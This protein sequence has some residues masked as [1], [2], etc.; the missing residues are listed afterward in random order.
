MMKTRRK[1]KA[2]AETA[3]AVSNGGDAGPFTIDIPDDVDTDALAAVLPDAS[4]TTPSPDTVLA[5]YRLV[6][7]QGA[8]IDNANRELDAATAEA[9][10]KGIELEQVYQ[11]KDNVA[12]DAEAAVEAANAELAAAKK[13]RDELAA[14]NTKLKAEL[15]A[16]TS[17]QSSSSTEVTELKRRVEDVEREKR[18]LV[19][20]ITRLKQENGQREEEVTTLR[21]NLKDA[22]HDHEQLE[23]QLRELRSAES[24]NKFKLDTLQQQLTLAQNEVQRTT[25]SLNN[26]TEAYATYRRTKHQEMLA[27]QTSHAALQTQYDTLHANHAALESAHSQQTHALQSAQARIQELS[28][29]LGDHEAAYAS[30]VGGL[31]RLVAIMEEREKQSREIVDKVEGSWAAM[32]EKAEAREAE[33]LAEIAR[34]EKERDEAESRVRRLETVVERMGRGELPIANGGTSMPGTPVRGGGADAGISLLSPTVAMASRAQKGGKTFTEVYAEYVKLQDDFAKKSAECE[35]MERT[36]TQVLAQIEERAPI[37]S[38]QRAEYERVSAE[39]ALLSTQLSQAIVERDTLATSNRD[40]EQKLAKALKEGALL[41]K[42]AD[43]LGRQVRHLTRE[44]ARLRDPSLPHDIDADDGASVNGSLADGRSVLSAGTTAINE[45]AAMAP[46]ES[47]DDVIANH[48]VLFNSVPA[49]Q[50]QNRRLLL[51][52]RQLGSRMEDAEREWREEAEREQLA[53][54]REA[55]EAMTEMANQLEAARREMDERSAAGEANRREREALKAMVNRLQRGEHLEGEQPRAV[56]RRPV[57]E[58]SSADEESELTRLRAYKAEMESDAGRLR[59][60][61]G[62]AQREIG[63]LT[64]ALAKANARAEYLTERARDSANQYDV[65]LAQLKGLEQR[66][67]QLSDQL[68][69]L[70]SEAAR[71]TDELVV[72][73]GRVEQLRNE[74]ANLR[75]EKQLASSAQAQL[76]EANQ[77]LQR[78]RLQLTD[79]LS[80]VQKMNASL[81]GAERGERS[82]LER[83]TSGS[84]F[85]RSA[86]PSGRRPCRRTWSSASCRAALSAQRRSRRRRASPWSQRRPAASTSRTAATWRSWLSTS[87]TVRSRARRARLQGLPAATRKVCR[88]KWQS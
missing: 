80:N 31:K 13:E 65:Q 53:A 2:A 59:D 88:P 27:L 67:A 14:A 20:V 57:P 33:L 42:N 61:L 17:S 68:I 24:T 82:R 73:Q 45:I 26:T 55:H 1:A 39:A 87:D 21:K 35:H 79:L 30:E 54:V 25:E 81:E 8:D 56:E 23:N 49:L 28:G 84:K 29:R 11:D 72:A 50:A 18:D 62:A 86:M 37:L 75:A 52:V 32:V 83:R 71:A 7:A 6:L 16:V 19:T 38:Q 58:S 4:F 47:V 78:E 77:N 3:S 12:R 44:N 66:N 85:T 9:E 74:C 34:V 43:D 51:L 48:L 10:K 76:L 41:E 46:A 70:D 5:L 36:L 60:E 63:K 22:R 69:R 15:N 40:N 64:A